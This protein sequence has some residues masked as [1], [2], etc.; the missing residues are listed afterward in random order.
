M[1]LDSEK[2]GITLCTIHTSL[3]YIL[4]TCS[5]KRKCAKPKFQYN[6]LYILPDNNKVV[7]SHHF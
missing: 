1:P 3:Y 4:G 5:K 7:Y 6:Y 2:T